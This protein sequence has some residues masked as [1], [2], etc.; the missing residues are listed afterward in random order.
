MEG[1]DHAD[2]IISS[3]GVSMGEKVRKKSK[4][5]S[6]FPILRVFIDF[7]IRTF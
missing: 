7:L 4:T 1:L 6:I 5:I 2:V 3:G